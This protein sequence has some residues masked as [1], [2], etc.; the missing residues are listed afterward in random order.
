MNQEITSIKV[1]LIIVEVCDGMQ[2]DSIV[3]GLIQYEVKALNMRA[4]T[5]SNIN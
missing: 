4:Y 1:N 5:K 3:I 2:R